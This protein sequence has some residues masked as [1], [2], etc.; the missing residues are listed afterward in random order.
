MLMALAF[1]PLYISFLGIEAYGIIGF[2]TTL[3]AVFSIMDLGI[4][5]TLNRELARRSADP[6]PAQAQDM[7]DLVRTLEIIYWGI[8]ALI[9]LSVILLAPFIARHW[10]HAEHLSESTIEQA[11]MLIGLVM[12]VQWP[13]MFYSGGLNG[14]QHQVLNNVIA[15]GV[16]TLRFAGAVLVLWLVSP[17]LEAYFQW[18][19]LVSILG[20]AATRY[21]LWRRL[22]TGNQRSRF[23]L[24][25]L[26]PVWRFAVG[27]TGISII[28]L[29]R[30]QSD[31]VILST[32]LPL[33][34][35][36]YYSLASLVAA[37]SIFLVVPIFT[38]MF[39]RFSQLVAQDDEPA[40]ARLYH[41]ASQLAS[42]AVIPMVLIV[43][44]FSYNLLYIWTGNLT[45]TEN[46]YILVSLLAI[47]Y[48]LN[49]LMHMPFAL[50]LA[51]GW[52]ELTIRLGAVFVPILVPMLFWVVPKYGAVGAAWVWVIINMG[53]VTIG[54][55]L[56]HRRLLTGEKWR[57][58]KMDVLMPLSAALLVSS[59]S[60]WIM[61][62]NLGRLAGFGW[63]A[64]SF[65]LMLAATILAAPLLRDQFLAFMPVRAKK[66]FANMSQQK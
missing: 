59:L 35:F 29:F 16:A 9:G 25:L 19:I 13:I 38:A 12:A 15:S 66:Y 2:Y 33:E 8:A 45:T 60:L 54:I 30:V 61:P 14:L 64:F 55:S 23:R 11:I 41:Q 49:G 51:S 58:Y 63:I 37:A 56:M 34:M 39:P 1:V 62:D 32:L 36:G 28:G 20:V 46:T 52:P 57:W 10:L 24:P 40:L 26:R 27:M 50:Q 6:N 47:G 44:F 42:I 5:T 7:R 22:P 4:G 18:Q 21:F 17:T 65:G 43:V 53:Y 48:G 3:S 31:K